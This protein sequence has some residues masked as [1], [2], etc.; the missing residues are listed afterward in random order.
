MPR[1]PIRKVG[2]ISDTMLVMVIITISL[3]GLRQ[4]K[5]DKCLHVSIQQIIIIFPPGT[6]KNNPQNE[7]EIKIK[8][9]DIFLLTR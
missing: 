5:S 3:A 6:Y 9:R 2:E 7:V 4:R 8:Y 1:E